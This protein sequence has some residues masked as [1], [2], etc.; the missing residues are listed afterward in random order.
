MLCFGWRRERFVS[1]TGDMSLLPFHDCAQLPNRVKTKRAKK[2]DNN[3]N[4][5]PFTQTEKVRQLNK[6][7]KKKYSTS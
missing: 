2:K 3:P 1:V 5:K 7:T 4:N 6:K